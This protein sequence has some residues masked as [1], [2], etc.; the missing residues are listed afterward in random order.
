MLPINITELIE[1]NR[2]ESNRIGYKKGWIQRLSTILS[3]PLPM[4]FK[5]K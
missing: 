1:Q 5:E 3:A 2:T 4:T